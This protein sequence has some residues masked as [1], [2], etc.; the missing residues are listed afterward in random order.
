[1]AFDAVAVIG[2][3]RANKIAE[4]RPGRCVRTGREAPGIAN[5]C[6]RLLA[7]GFQILLRQEGF[8]LMLFGIHL[9]RVYCRLK[10]YIC[11]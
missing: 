1:M 5:D 7:K 3:H 6:A 9:C 11:Y 10:V 2:I 4:F 8:E